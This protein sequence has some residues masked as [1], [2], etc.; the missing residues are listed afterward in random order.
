MMRSDI[1]EIARYGTTI[2]LPMAMGTSGYLITRET[3][4][5]MS[6]AGI[7]SVAISLDAADPA[8][9]DTFRGCRGS[10]ER[11]V[12][13]IR[14]CLKEGIRVQINT[15][16][17]TPDQDALDQ[18]IRLGQDLGVRDFQVFI[19]VPT[20]RSA[21]ENYERYG[22]YEPLI[23]HILKTW[24]GEGISLR[25]TCFPQF[26]RIASETGVE[27]KSWGRGCIAGRSYCRI[28]ADGTVTP[29]PYLP[30]I[31]GDL[32]ETCFSDIWNDSPVFTALRD[33]G[34]L[35]GKCGICEYQE[36][37][38]GCRARAFSV[39]QNITGSFGKLVPP[40]EPIGE[41]CADD[42][43]CPYQPGGSS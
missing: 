28:Y 13:A 17:I 15:T 26:R 9:H 25:P 3:P 5:L 42:P 34:S 36:I 6:A 39:Y 11:A 10:W 41:L 2:G 8:S 29:C 19:P 35:S 24:T 27:N 31:A 4:S 38:G 20:G 12:A 16:V 22:T 30:V 21:K 32:R 18:V 40:E 33:A 43:L 1:F 14:L 37:C 23:R 7:R